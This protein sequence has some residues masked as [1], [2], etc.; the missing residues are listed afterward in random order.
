[1]KI[2]NNVIS[3]PVNSHF[4]YEVSLD[5]IKSEGVESWVSYL[6]EKNWFTLKKELE[7]VELCKKC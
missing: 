5:R 1:M 2:K 6:K 3:I 7:F 4:S